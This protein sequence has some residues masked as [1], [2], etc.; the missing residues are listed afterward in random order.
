MFFV[1]DKDKISLFGISESNISQVPEEAFEYTSNAGDEETAQSSKLQNLNLD[2]E[3]K[4]KFAHIEKILDK[5]SKTLEKQRRSETD[6]EESKDHSKPKNIPAEQLLSSENAHNSPKTHVKVCSLDLEKDE[7][8]P[9]NLSEEKHHEDMQEKQD[10]EIIQPNIRD[11]T[12]TGSQISKSEDSIASRVKIR[13]GRTEREHRDDKPPFQKAIEIEDSKENA[14]NPFLNNP[15]QLLGMLNKGKEALDK[16]KEDQNKPE[17]MPSSTEESKGDLG[18]KKPSDVGPTDNK[19]QEESKDDSSLQPQI[20]KKAPTVKISDENKRE[21]PHRNRMPQNIETIE[22]SCCQA[23]TNSNNNKY[24]KNIENLAAETIRRELPK[25][26][27]ENVKQTVIT[28]IVRETKDKF[29]GIHNKNYKFLESTIMAFAEKKIDELKETAEQKA[30][31][32][33]STVMTDELKKILNTTIIPQCEKVVEDTMSE[34]ISNVKDALDENVEKV[35]EMEEKVDKF[36]SENL[37]KAS[38]EPSVSQGFRPFQLEEDSFNNLLSS[39]FEHAPQEAPREPEVK[40]F[41]SHMS[42]P[43]RQMPNTGYTGGFGGEP[44]TVGGM[45]QD[46]SSSL[47]LSGS[48][49]NQPM[50]TPTY[51]PSGAQPMGSFGTPMSQGFQSPSVDDNYTKMVKSLHYFIETNIN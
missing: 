12:T 51:P 25:L 31:D 34:L 42:Q 35:K 19:F 49:W 22:C 43:S 14:Q 39:S 40:G 18:E 26:L 36:I 46:F 27:Q 45:S 38:Q 29:Q 13:R 30:K 8:H 20:I 47:H 2:S 1:R 44:F 5:S 16:S 11:R 23:R 7:S 28:A 32:A 6:K 37:K 10:G 3:D 4:E 15:N 48:E 17:Q 24:Q 21:E 33:I 50:S 9:N 41:F